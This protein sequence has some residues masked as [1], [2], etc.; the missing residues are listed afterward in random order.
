MSYAPRFSQTL[1]FFKMALGYAP[2]NKPDCLYLNWNYR[3]ENNI[4]VKYSSDDAITPLPFY[5]WNYSQNKYLLTISKVKGIQVNSASVLHVFVW[6][7]AFFVIDVTMGIL[8]QANRWIAQCAINH[9]V[10]SEIWRG[11]WKP[12]TKQWRWMCL[13]TQII[14]IQTTISMSRMKSS[15]MLPFWWT[16]CFDS[17]STCQHSWTICTKLVQW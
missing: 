7:T 5:K 11:T 14:P 16:L 3:W 9:L 15:T 13:E 17:H 6:D 4:H 8:K 12:F 2:Q 1:P 10:Q